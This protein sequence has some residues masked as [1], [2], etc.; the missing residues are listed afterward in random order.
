MRQGEMLKVQFGDIDFRRQLI[1]LRAQTTKSRKRRTIPISTLRLKAVLEWLRLD[2]EGDKKSDETLVF[3][4]EAGERI[5]RFRTA[6][7]TAV[8]KAHGIAPKWRSY[9]WTA[10]TPD[11]QQQFRKINLRWHDLRHDTRHASSS[12]ASRSRRFAICWVTHR[13]RRP[14]DMTTR[15]LKICKPPC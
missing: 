6:W 13:S 2:A 5:G 8:L 14:N 7:V 12:A 11:C 15:S 1:V 10:L 3:S 9:N 4:N